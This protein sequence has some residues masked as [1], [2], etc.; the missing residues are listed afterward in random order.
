[1]AANKS[2]LFLIGVFLAFFTMA[3]SALGF[4][5]P[6][7]DSGS[8]PFKY[9]VTRGGTGTYEDPYWEKISTKPGAFP[10]EEWYGYRG[11][12]VKYDETDVSLCNVGDCVFID[13]AVRQ[14]EFKYQIAPL[15]PANTSF[16][17]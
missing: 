9:D 16:R 4:D 5:G 3:S 13:Q 8:I 7:S 2:R 6:G 11:Q 1:M 15:P 14:Q 12:T 10:F 17:I